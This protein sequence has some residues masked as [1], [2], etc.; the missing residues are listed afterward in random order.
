MLK[1]DSY[2]FPVGNAGVPYVINWK[3]DQITYCRDQM[4][5]LKWFHPDVQ[6]FVTV[7]F[8]ECFKNK[9]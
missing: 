4:S 7:Y 3:T 1:S 9:L 5:Q 2:G 8:K 6:H